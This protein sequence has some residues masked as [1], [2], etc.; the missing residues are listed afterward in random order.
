VGNKAGIG[1][2]TGEVRSHGRILN[3]VGVA[4]TNVRQQTGGSIM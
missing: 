4:C 1:P 2:V 3:W